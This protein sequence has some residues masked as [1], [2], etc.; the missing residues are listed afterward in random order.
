MT[1]LNE[2]EHKFAEIS[3]QYLASKEEVAML[4]KTELDLR[5]ELE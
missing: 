5:N 3:K 4:R 2:L 1:R